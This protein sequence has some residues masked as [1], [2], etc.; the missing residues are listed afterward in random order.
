MASG[1]IWNRRTAVAGGAALAAGSIWAL[2]GPSGPSHFAIPGKG[3]LRRGNGAE[4]ETLDNSLSTGD[5]DDHI[6]GD[7]MV[8]LVTE[9]LTAE[10]VP[11][12]AAGWT[13]SPDGLTWRFKLREAEW[14]DGVPITAED[15]VFSWRRLLDP[16]TAAR[17][18]YYLYVV[19]NAEAINA[20]RQP[21]SALGISAIGDHE[22]EVRLEH[23]APYLLQMLM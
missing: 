8:G 4:P 16:A 5:S 6:I 19:K 1:K 11:G 22:L 20:G 9:S 17:Y 14:S 10:P 23:P 12:I 3:T 18:A 7:L 2:R 13:T 21:A 15:V